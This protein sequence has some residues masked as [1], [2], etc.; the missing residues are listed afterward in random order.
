MQP[1][2]KIKRIRG[3]KL[4]ERNA[5]ILDHEP[6]CRIC[7]AAGRIAAATEVDHIVALALG[8]TE[9]PDNL[10]PVCATCNDEKAAAE[11]RQLAKMNQY[12]GIDWIY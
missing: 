5:W 10:Q 4:Q 8:G 1:T 3:R 9:D 6:L 7:K 12:P 2:E 11:V